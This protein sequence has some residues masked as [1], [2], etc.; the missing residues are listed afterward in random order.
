MSFSAPITTR[1]IKNLRYKYPIIHYFCYAIATICAVLFCVFITVLQFIL[2]ENY[3]I[4][5]RFGI[6]LFIIFSVFSTVA[7]FYS[8]IK[9]K[10]MYDFS[11]D[12]SKKR[13]A[14]RL[15]ASKWILPP[16]QTQKM[17][18]T[19]SKK[20]VAKN[21][22]L[23]SIVKLIS[24]LIYPKKKDFQ[25][26]IL[27]VLG[28]LT[29]K[30]FVGGQINVGYSLKQLFI[31]FFVV[32]FLIYQA[33]YQWNDIR[34][35]TEDIGSGKEDRLFCM[36]STEGQQNAGERKK[37]KRA[38][39]VSL[40]IMVLK[41]IVA[42]FIILVVDNQMFFPLLSCSVLVFLI[43]TLYEEARTKKRISLVFILGL[44]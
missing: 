39:I 7:F 42:C 15:R 6:A 12:E 36:L 18:D 40:I 26:P 14:K 31:L 3:S 2:L 16:E 34:G 25:K 24:Y 30:L 41:I 17:K 20:R 21:G 29:G 5:D 37:A 1:N 11:L 35:L 8:S 43:A 28:F 33:R 38:V 44:V 23:K 19:K 22:N 10:H 27:L 9:A 32:D 4:L 13:Q